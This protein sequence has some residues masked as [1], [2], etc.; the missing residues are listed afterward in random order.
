MLV[1][2]GEDR[3]NRREP[4]RIDYERRIVQWFGTI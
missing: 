3:S 4:N 1:Y 2:G